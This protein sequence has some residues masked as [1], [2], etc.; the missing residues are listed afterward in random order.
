MDIC[1]NSFSTE[2]NKKIAH[3]ITRLDYIE[4]KSELYNYRSLFAHESLLQK[5]IADFFKNLSQIVILIITLIGLPAAYYAISI[6][7][8]STKNIYIILSLYFIGILLCICFAFKSK[9]HKKQCYW[10]DILA[11]HT[12]YIISE[13]LRKNQ[14]TY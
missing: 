13:A 1:I 7:G 9:N 4:D 5:K 8:L 14:I 3:A 11:K 12:D 2:N 10:Y 6:I